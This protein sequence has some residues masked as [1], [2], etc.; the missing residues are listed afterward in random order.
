MED[1]EQLQQNTSEWIKSI[2]KVTAAKKSGQLRAK[3]AY[4]APVTLTWTQT[5]IRSPDL[6][7]IKKRICELAVQTT[8]PDELQYLRAYPEA[9]SY[10]M[11]LKPCAPFFEEGLKAVNW[12]LV[13]DKIGA[14]LRQFYHADLSSFAAEV[15]KPLIND[16]HIF[17][18][19]QEQGRE[20]IRGYVM[21]SAT[22]ALSY[23]D[24]K[25]INLALV[26]AAKDRGLDALLLSSIFKIVPEVKRL[27]QFVRPTNEELITQYYSLGFT[28]DLNPD[29]DPNHIVNPRSFIRLEYDV[30]EADLLQ[31]LSETIVSKQ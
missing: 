3:D 19:L 13:E 23:G 4:D 17:V 28:A 11:F 29:Q 14:T 5:H 7:A 31:E 9:V 25:V 10:E 6:A 22:P 30:N 1:L 21:F 27:F 2:N 16:I 24:M 12:K 26:P 8:V 18:M 20:E 15:I